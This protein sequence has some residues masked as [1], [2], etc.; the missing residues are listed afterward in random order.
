MAHDALRHLASG[1]RFL[2]YTGS[3]IMGGTDLL[4]QE[5]AR[6]AASFSC[7]L[8]YREID[9]DVFGEE[10]VSAAYREVDRIA[11]VG[12]VFEKPI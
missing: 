2:L 1:G 5:L 4:R 8:D 7:R 10:L 12:A 3:A 6:M 11:V 9:P